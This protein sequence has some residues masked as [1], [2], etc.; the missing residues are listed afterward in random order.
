M[1]DFR[2]LVVAVTGP[3]IFGIGLP[4]LTVV[5]ANSDGKAPVRCEINERQQGGGVSLEAVVQGGKALNG[6]YRFVV[7]AGSNAGNSDI[8]QSGPLN[9]AASGALATV[10]LGPGVYSAKLDVTIDGR[11]F[12]CSKRGGGSL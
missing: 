3:V 7:S 6:S 9:D 10:H 8:E 11:T 1:L 4:A 2:K 5:A 12:R